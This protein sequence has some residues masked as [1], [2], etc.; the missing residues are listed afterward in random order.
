MNYKVDESYRVIFENGSML[1]LMPD[2][3]YVNYNGKLQEGVTYSE[4]LGFYQ[5]VT[6]DGTPYIE[7]IVS[8]VK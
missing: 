3:L 2:K 7:F 4:L 5:E 1:E 8:T 6:P